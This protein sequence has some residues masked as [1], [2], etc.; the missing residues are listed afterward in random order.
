MSTPLVTRIAAEAA[1]HSEK[2]NHWIIGVAALVILL[3]ALLALLFF[4]GG[5]EHS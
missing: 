4:A 5:R 2:V 1:E 3:G